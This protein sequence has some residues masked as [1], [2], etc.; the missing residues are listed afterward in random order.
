MN[1]RGIVLIV[2]FVSG[3]AFYA[4]KKI[5]SSKFIKNGN[6]TMLNTS[7]NIT[8][9]K[10]IDNVSDE[11]TVKT[12]IVSGNKIKIDVTKRLSS[13]S[14]KVNNKNGSN[15]TKDKVTIFD[16]SNTIDTQ[17]NEQLEDIN[18]TIDYSGGS[19]IDVIKRLSSD[20]S[21]VSNKSESISIKDKTTIFDFSSMIDT[22]VNKQLEDINQII[23]YNGKSRIYATKSST[24]ESSKVGNKNE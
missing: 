24:N 14:L 11:E 21:K 8:H 13:D 18:K 1:I 16:F 3:V 23:D 22:Q 15:S 19:R 20:S 12:K 17:V 2:S 5:N 6:F 4:G 7:W 10:Q 9:P